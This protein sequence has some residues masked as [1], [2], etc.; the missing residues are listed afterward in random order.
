MPSQR[1]PRRL[2]AAGLY[3]LCPVTLGLGLHLGQP[4]VVVRKLV[5]VRPGD[6]PGDCLVVV[7][8]VRR[9]I[10]TPMF[11]LDFEPHSKLLQLEPRTAPVD[12][13]SLTDITG[14]LCR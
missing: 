6:L 12:T 7:S 13:N 1:R 3:P 8:D 2:C 10:P 14:P 5:E 4:G 9:G 11:E